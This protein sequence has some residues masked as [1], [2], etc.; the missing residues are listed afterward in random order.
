MSK[1]PTRRVSHK[2][3]LLTS[4]AT[5][6][7]TLMIEAKV[8][9]CKQD[10]HKKG[11]LIN[12]ITACH[13]QLRNKK[14]WPYWSFLHQILKHHL[15][16]LSFTYEGDGVLN[17]S[18]PTY[19]TIQDACKCT[20]TMTHRIALVLFLTICIHAQYVLGYS[21]IFHLKPVI[22][23]LFQYNYLMSRMTSN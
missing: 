17:T 4:N 13:Q 10:L 1:S 19:G 7:S 8:Q 20:Q 9:S 16:T 18:H 23:F 5:K 12:I 11:P 3:S 21:Q 22:R 2:A 6:Y 15:N 14:F